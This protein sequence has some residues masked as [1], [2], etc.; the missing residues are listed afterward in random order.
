M[1]GV[2]EL[3]LSEVA[4]HNKEDDMWIVIDGGVYDVTSFSNFHPG[5]KGV[6][7]RVAGTDCT[8]E[9]YGLHKQAVLDKYRSKLLVGV[10][11]GSLEA[12]R[13]PNALPQFAEY[14]KVPFA[15][16]ESAFHNES[17]K[18]FR[19][20]VRKIVS[21]LIMPEVELLEISNKPPSA[22]LIAKIGKTGLI[23]CSLG[24]GKHLEYVDSLPGGLKPSEFDWH[25]ACI[26]SEEM[27]RIGS[28]GVID[29]FS[30]GTVIGTPP[31]I[32]FGSQELID[33]VVKPVVRG[34]KRIALAITDPYAG[35]DVANTTCTAELS[36]DGSYYTVNGLKK[37]ITTGM[38][39]DFFSTAVRTG[40]E[41]HGG[42]SMLLIPRGE[43]V[44]T[45]AIRTSYTS[46]A[47][48]AL[49]IFDNVKVPA[50]NILGKVNGGF[51]VIM[52]NFNQERFMMAVGGNRHNRLVIEDCFKWAVQRKVF[53]KPLINQPQIQE[54]L[55]TMIGQCNAVSAWIDVVTEQMNT[56]SHH[57]VA[58][59]LAGTISMLKNQQV[60][61]SR[62]IV[63][64]ALQI[65]GGRGLTKTGMGRNVENL[66]RTFEFG[67][68]LGGATSVLATQ[69]IRHTL[70][71]YPADAR[72]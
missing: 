28:T 53:G 54:R 68:V 51:Q 23:A 42:I 70:K 59:K 7:V 10:I 57:D 30:G 35:S 26:V 62:I 25:H 20:A 31:V 18:K 19:M 14:S 48:T 46:A 16:W 37:W 3:S 43:G 4:K 55:A 40:K 22:E 71:G 49:V 29:G 21:D 1:G 38:P 32:N 45:K 12:K 66:Q 9:F 58:V 67:G 47:G 65:M 17:H 15:E 72:L 50:K 11:P 27:K 63:D 41:L 8:D 52:S 2:K 33:T 34:E 36:A 13:D 61:A 44:E 5:S 39:A 6:L 69:A 60:A 64:C 56:M 24:V